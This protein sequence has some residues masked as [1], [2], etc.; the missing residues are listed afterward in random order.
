MF[1]QEWT[2]MNYRRARQLYVPK[3]AYSSKQS[4]VSVKNEIST[5]WRC[6]WFMCLLKLSCLGPRLSK[7]NLLRPPGPQYYTSSAFFKGCEVGSGR[8]HVCACSGF[9]ALYA[10]SLNFWARGGS[11][12]SLERPRCPARSPWD[13]RH[14][15][16]VPE[17]IFLLRSSHAQ[18]SIRS[19]EFCGILAPVPKRRPPLLSPGVVLCVFC[20][21]YVI[22]Q[23]IKVVKFAANCCSRVP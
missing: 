16:V 10:K 9:G 5:F 23:A 21:F 11:E 4:K 3:L 7:I 18:V 22:L 15:T 19:S 20:V 2:L 12:V 1:S 13:F 14:G 17:W 6:A 8:I